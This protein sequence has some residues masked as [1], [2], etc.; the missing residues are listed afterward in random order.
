VPTAGTGVPANREAGPKG[1]RH[2]L[3]ELRG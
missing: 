2:G 3:R 1:E